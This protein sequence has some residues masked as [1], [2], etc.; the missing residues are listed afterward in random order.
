MNNR[1]SDSQFPHKIVVRGGLY[2][3]NFDSWKCASIYWPGS[4]I[5][6]YCNSFLIEEYKPESEGKGAIKMII[7]VCLVFVKIIFLI[8]DTSPK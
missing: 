7:L 1:S 8:L 6:S 3:I 5:F 2:E 4:K